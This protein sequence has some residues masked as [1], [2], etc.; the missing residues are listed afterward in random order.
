MQMENLNGNLLNIAHDIQA[1]LIVPDNIMPG[2][3]QDLVKGKYDF[4]LS[5]IIFAG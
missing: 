1:K 4:T 3:F 2:P 5:C